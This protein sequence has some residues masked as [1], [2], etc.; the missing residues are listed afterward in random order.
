MDKKIE[1]IQKINKK[2]K[3]KQQNELGSMSKEFLS[4][5][6]KGIYNYIKNIDKHDFILYVMIFFIIFFF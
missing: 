4:D 2:K 3:E 5:K 1:N 6:N